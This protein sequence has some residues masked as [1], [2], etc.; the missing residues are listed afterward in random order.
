[1][2]WEEFLE[3]IRTFKREYS[4][5]QLKL[6]AGG[7]I[8]LVYAGAFDSMMPCNPTCEDYHRMVE[9]IKKALG[10]NAEK[11]K[12]KKGDMFGVADIKDEM[13]LDLWRNE[14]NP[15]HKFDLM[16]N[17]QGF[18]DGQAFKKNKHPLVPYVRQSPGRYGETVKT[19]L[20]NSWTGAF[21]DNQLKSILLNKN[22]RYLYNAAFVGMVS[23]AVIKPLK[24]GR[25]SLVF[26]LHIATEQT[27]SIRVW[28]NDK[29]FVEYKYTSTIVPGNIG[30]LVANLDIWNDWRRGSL[31]DWVPVNK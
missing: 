2:I 29:G 19:L 3:K 23:E 7:L 13:T 10:S 18:L 24:D 16:Q 26:K 21:E 11:Q 5:G 6:N 14:V 8:T 25:E 4:S 22:N 27:G 12:A 17:L 9:E 31:V 1:M 30:L 20:L 28:P 15:L